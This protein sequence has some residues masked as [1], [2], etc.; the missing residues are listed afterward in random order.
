MTEG[1]R[2]L[3]AARTQLAA[4]SHAAVF[5]YHRFG[6]VVGTAASGEE[7]VRKAVAFRPDWIF[8][9]CPLPDPSAAET[10]WEIGER[11][12]GARIVVLSARWNPVE[13]VRLVK[14]GAMSYLPS[15]LDE[16]GLRLSLEGIFQGRRTFPDEL[17][18]L[19][20]ERD[21]ELDS[22]KYRQLTRREREITRLAA[23]GL[24]NKE[25]GWECGIRVRTVETH[26]R[27]IRRKTGT[28]ST[29]DLVRFAE[30]EGLA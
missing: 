18:R 13:A 15:D 12:R 4:A 3:V 7:A 20:G 8:L 11:I 29:A 1:R 6:T 26:R 21:Y 10:V 27:N 30:E 5:R 2:I 28:R 25:I 19:L 24:S 22:R 9:E 17:L 16:E 14:A 23:S